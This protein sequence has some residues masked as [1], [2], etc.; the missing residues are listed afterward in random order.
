[1]VTLRKFFTVG[2][3]I[4][5]KLNADDYLS[6]ISADNDDKENLKIFFRFTDKYDSIMLIMTKVMGYCKEYP[7]LINLIETILVARVNFGDDLEED[8]KRH[9]D[10]F[11][12]RNEEEKGK[13]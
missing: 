8:E 3:R 9:I 13:H 5:Q 1:M 10:D 2:C 12:R 11:L 6:A 7:R 4:N